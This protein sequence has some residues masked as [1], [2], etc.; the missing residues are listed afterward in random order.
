MNEIIEQVGYD[1]GIAALQVNVTG[2]LMIVSA[3]YK[4]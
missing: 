3:T 4:K 1:N 2:E